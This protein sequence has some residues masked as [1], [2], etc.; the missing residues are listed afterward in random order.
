LS[1]S[2]LSN[3]GFT[4]PLFLTSTVYLIKQTQPMKSVY[5]K[6]EIRVFGRQVN[7]FPLGV[8]EAFDSIVQKLPGGFDRSF[9]GISTMGENGIRYIA[10]AEER[11]PAEPSDYGYE[12]F[13]IERGRYAARELKD[14]REK[15][16][17]IKDV[18]QELMRENKDLDLSRPCVEWYKDD[19]RMICMIKRKEKRL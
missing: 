3:G 2:T 4:P 10:A 6:N 9:Y 7:S 1:Q 19:E 13:V 12:S 16:E 5:L 15:I 17:C 8:G 18:F 14:W 11:H